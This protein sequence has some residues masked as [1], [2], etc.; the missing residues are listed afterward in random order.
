[1]NA[2]SETVV[3]VPSLELAERE[4]RMVTFTVTFCT[5]YAV[6]Y[7]IGLPSLIYYPTLGR[8]SF[9]S[10]ASSGEPLIAMRWFGWVLTSLAGAGLAAW[11][12]PTRFAWRLW[13][14]A[15]LLPWLLLILIVAHEWRWFQR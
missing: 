5:L 4:A 11:V 2:T 12:V 1:M 3:L 13:G 6:V 7:G 8:F 14:A 9:A 10:L 15:S